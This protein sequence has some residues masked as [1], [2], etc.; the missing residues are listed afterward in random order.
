MGKLFHLIT[1]LSLIDFGCSVTGWFLSLSLSLILSH[2][3][4]LSDR[5]LNIH[6]SRK[7]LPKHQTAIHHF[8][9]IDNFH[10]SSNIIWLEYRRVVDNS[11]NVG[12]LG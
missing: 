5:N 3:H 12:L 2:I 11:A 8:Q 6:K 10:A 1:P 9:L 7:Q 4:S